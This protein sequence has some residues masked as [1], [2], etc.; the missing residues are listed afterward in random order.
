ML[1][2]KKIYIDSRHRTA[3]SISASNFRYELP[4]SLQMPDNTVFYICDICIPM[5]LDL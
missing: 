3:D 4:S 5:S 1:P 2:I